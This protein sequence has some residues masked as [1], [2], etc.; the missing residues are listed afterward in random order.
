[1][2]LDPELAALLDAAPAFDPEKLR[3]TPVDEYRAVMKQGI[4]AMGPSPEVVDS[5]V[6]T[7]IPGPGR[8]AARCGSTRPRTT[9]P[10]GSRCSSTGAGS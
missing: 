10:S 2:P 9:R 1:M 8:R 5:V 3:T 7:T 6:D 4:L